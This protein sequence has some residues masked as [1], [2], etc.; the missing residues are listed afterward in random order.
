MI[1]QRNLKD[2][3]ICSI[4]M[5]L[6]KSYAEI[7]RDVRSYHKMRHGKA[8]DGICD[9]IERA[10]LWK[11]GATFKTHTDFDLVKTKKGFVWQSKNLAKFIGKK[12][13]LISVPSINFPNKGHLIYWDGE[14]LHDPSNL[15]RYTPAKAFKCAYRAVVQA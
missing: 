8:F 1:K 3:G 12:K 4:A 2:C 13:A 5:F 7:D 6:G 11:H 14:K 15:K 9:E 10:V